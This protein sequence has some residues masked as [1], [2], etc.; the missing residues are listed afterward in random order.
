MSL[1]PTPNGSDLCRREL[2]VDDIARIDR[3]TRHLDAGMTDASGIDM[4]M[5][6]RVVVEVELDDQTV[7]AGDSGHTSK[8]RVGLRRYSR[9][10]AKDRPAGLQTT[11]HCAFDA[12]P[13]RFS[14]SSTA[15]APRDEFEAFE[16]ELRTLSE[17]TRTDDVFAHELY[18]ALCNMR[19]RRRDADTEP[20][21]MSWRYAGGASP[22][23]PA[24]PLLWQQGRRFRTHPGCP[25]AHW[26]GFELRDRRTKSERP[27][28][29]GR[30]LAGQGQ[31]T[32]TPSTYGRH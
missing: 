6:R 32:V 14:A 29:P 8:P 15:K 27:S 5:W 17:H 28:N 20:A 19:W 26:G 9:P 12:T 22:T 21:S 4:D 24:R 31:G 16:V 23:L 2:A 7:E 11:S 25:G 30:S 1:T 13:R 18:D 3:D 10:Q